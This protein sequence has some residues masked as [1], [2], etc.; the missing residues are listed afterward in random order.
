MIKQFFIA[1]LAASSMISSAQAFDAKSKPVNVI[2]PFSPGGGVDQ[3]F[4]HF[5]RWAS[6]RGINFNPIYKPGAEGLIGMND[7]AG[8][9]KDGYHISFGTAGTVAVQRIKNPS[10]ELELVTGIKNSVTAFVTHRDSGIKEFGDLYKIESL[11]MAYGAPGQKMSM[12]QI[13][14][15]SKG[16]IKGKLIPYKGGGP[17]VQDI[18]GNHVQLGAVPLQIVKQHI[19][20]GT[21]RLLALGN[22]LKEFPNTPNIYKFFPDWKRQD[23]FAFIMPKGSDP[24]AVKFWTELIK[25]YMNDKKV[26]EEFAKD[27]NE[28]IPFGKDTLESIVS[29]AVSSLSKN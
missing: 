9:P 10:A 25:E 3:T 24:Q 12:E 13:L 5:E 7:I 27:F 11:S 21:V 16:K 17:V 18:V 26:Q 19:D 15:L 14:D 22:D 8:M 28:S 29:S 4:R 2:I 1:I 23:C 20:A 6:S